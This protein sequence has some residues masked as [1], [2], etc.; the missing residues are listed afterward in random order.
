MHGRIFI[1][2]IEEKKRRRDEGSFCHELFLCRG[3]F[4]RGGLVG[5]SC[6]HERKHIGHRLVVE[7]FVLCTL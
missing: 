4:I 7:A 6:A 1:P 2:E 3:E 5:D